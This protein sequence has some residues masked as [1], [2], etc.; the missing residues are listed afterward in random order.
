MKRCL[1]FLVFFHVIIFG[2][3]PTVLGHTDISIPDANDMIVS[4]SDLIIIDVREDYEY[5]GE[6]GH[7]PGAYNYPWTSGVLAA[8]YSD[9]LPN[10]E[11]LVICM[12]GGR[13]NLAANFLDSMGYLYVYDMLGGMNAWKNTYG[14]ETVGC[15]DSDND[16]FND[17]LDNCPN[18]ENPDQND[19]DD[20]GTGDV[21]DCLS[22]L[23]NDDETNIKDFAGFALQWSKTGCIVPDFCNAC[24]FNKSGTVDIV[25]LQIIVFQWLG[26]CGLPQ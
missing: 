11:I 4:N 21:C 10:D 1:V 23:D 22:D 13:S 24:D 17:D 19:M 2:F 7:V 26:N 18:I 5:C 3:S 6:L 16:G 25:D 9:F 12:T 15:I 20:D 8:S 14:Y